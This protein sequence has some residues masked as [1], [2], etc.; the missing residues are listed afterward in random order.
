[1]VSQLGGITSHPGNLPHHIPIAPP[2]P[3]FIP[4]A[5]DDYGGC[6]QQAPFQV[7]VW[8]RDEDSVSVLAELAFWTK[9][10]I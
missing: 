7:T 4:Q 10:T 2:L 1:M 6:S 5:H 9:M 3:W 8:S